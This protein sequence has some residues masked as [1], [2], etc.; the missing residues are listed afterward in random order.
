MTRFTNRTSR[1]NQEMWRPVLAM[2]AGGNPWDVHR[3]APFFNTNWVT[4]FWGMRRAPVAAADGVGGGSVPFI[5]FTHT[6][7]EPMFL[8]RTYCVFDLELPPAKAV[9]EENAMVATARASK[10]RRFIELL[11]QVAESEAL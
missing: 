8:I 4:A 10:T 6:G 9:L 11:Q 1:K 3:P 2:P 7:E 5:A